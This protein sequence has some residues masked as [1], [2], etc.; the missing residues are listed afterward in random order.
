M[1]EKKYGI[2]VIKIGWIEFCSFDWYVKILL[3]ILFGRPTMSKHVS[4]MVH[5]LSNSNRNIG[6]FC[7]KWTAICKE[8][9]CPFLNLM[10]HYSGV[11]S[12]YKDLFQSCIKV[13]HLL[14]SSTSWHNS[15]NSST[16]NEW[17][18]GLFRKCPEIEGIY[19][20]VCNQ[21]HFVSGCFYLNK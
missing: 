7:A 6:T 2:K 14:S 3:M 4:I 17:Q 19:C 9:Q 11:R 15:Q 5:I 20:T 8:S 16:T 1:V 13:S 18:W 10:K 12:K 21:V